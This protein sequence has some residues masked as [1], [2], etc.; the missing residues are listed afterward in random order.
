MPAPGEMAEILLVEDEPADAYLTRLAF[1]EAGIAAHL[2]HVGHGHE[3]LDFLHRRP[4][5]LEA[6]RPGLILLDL[7]MPRMNGY[8]FMTALRAEPAFADIPVVVLTTSDVERDIEATRNYGAADYIVKPVDMDAFCHRMGRLAS[9]W[10][11][12]RTGGDESSGGGPE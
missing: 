5:Y 11:L 6:P 4:P 3:A 8:E 12:P 7:N 1:E 9:E 2:H 10:R